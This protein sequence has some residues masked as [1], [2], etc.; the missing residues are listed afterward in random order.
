MMK[1]LS[2]RLRL[3]RGTEDLSVA[4]IKDMQAETYQFCVVSSSNSSKN[5]SRHRRHHASPPVPQSAIYIQN[6]KIEF[7]PLGPVSKQ[8]ERGELR[9]NRFELV[10][11]N[12][13]RRRAAVG[14][15]TLPPLC[16]QKVLHRF[17]TKTSSWF[18]NYYGEQRVGEPGDAAVRAPDIGRAMLQRNYDR[19]VDLILTGRKMVQG[20]PVVAGGAVDEFR[21]VWRESGKDAAA[22]MNAVKDNI[23]FKERAILTALKRFPNDPLA[24]LRSMPFHDRM[25][26]INAVRTV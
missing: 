5:A 17:Q 12:V 9:G 13:R 19:A 22:V 25:L 14:V 3:R 24:A 10:I 11:R 26:Y 18:V 6:H 23:P 15:G 4:G 8:L 21:R 2:Q 20:R 7:L 1:V 16:E